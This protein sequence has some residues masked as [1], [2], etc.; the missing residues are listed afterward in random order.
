MNWQ[1]PGEF[2]AMGGYA[3][4]VWGSVLACVVCVVGELVL[5]KGIG[6]EKTVV[7]HV[8]AGRIAEAAW[9]VQDGNAD[10]LAV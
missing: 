7:P 2:F 4:Y 9:V 5:R 8:P 10:R 3:L 1:S 6:G